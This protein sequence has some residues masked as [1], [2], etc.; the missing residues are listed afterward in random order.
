VAELLRETRRLL[1][2]RGTVEQGDEMI[3]AY[4]ATIRKPSR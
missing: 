1:F 2:L 3:A 4:S